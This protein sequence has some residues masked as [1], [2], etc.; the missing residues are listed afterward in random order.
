MGLGLK[1][2]AMECAARSASN[3]Q[4][5]LM[6]ALKPNSVSI[7]QILKNEKLVQWDDM[8]VLSVTKKLFNRQIN[9]YISRHKRDKARALTKVKNSVLEF[10]IEDSLLVS[11][12]CMCAV[13]SSFW[14]QDPSGL[15]IKDNYSEQRS[16]FTSDPVNR[17]RHIAT[18]C[19]LCVAF[20]FKKEGCNDTNCP[21]K[22][23]CVYHPTQEIQH[24]TMDCASNPS[25]W[26]NKQSNNFN[27]NNRYNNRRGRGRGRGY[28]Y[29][30]YNNNNNQYNPQWGYPPRGYQYPPYQFQQYPPNQGP[31]GYP[32]Q[33]PRPKNNIDRYFNKGNK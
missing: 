2:V 22:H 29:R 31:P 20:N 23:I 28:N 4:A 6:R 5:I 7:S 21:Y 19:G 32:G 9:Y 13:M 14:T 15:T 25:K 24:P 10:L 3:Q 30:R 8:L 12:P 33:D 17:V 1:Y 18:L 26:K 27:N 16:E 11:A